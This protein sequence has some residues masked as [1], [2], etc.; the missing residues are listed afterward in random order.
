LQL[1]H[2]L[3]QW[4]RVAQVSL[5]FANYSKWRGEGVLPLR[6]EKVIKAVI[7][8]VHL[9]GK[10]IRFWAAPDNPTGWQKMMDLNADI[11]STDKIDELVN[12]IK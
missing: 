4:Q 12:A 2:T 3:Q 7:N 11:L 9:T 8:A 5:N 6:D 10:K 1:P